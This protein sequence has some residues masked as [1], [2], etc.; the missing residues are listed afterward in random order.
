M[1]HLEGY[2]VTRNLSSLTKKVNNI[3]F[4]LLITINVLIVVAFFAVMI[5][6][7]YQ[8]IELTKDAVSSIEYLIENNG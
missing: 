8:N 4:Y 2:K 1:T 6:A 5:S 7:L 3:P